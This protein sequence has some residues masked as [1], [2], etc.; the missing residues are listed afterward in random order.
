MNGEV[1]FNLQTFLH[2]MRAEQTA[3]LSALAIEMRGGF[4]KIATTQTAHELEDQI[5]FSDLSNRM[6]PLESTQ[7]SLRWA[8][9]SMIGGLIVFLF[10][11]AHNWWK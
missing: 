1:S 3:A 11:A 2:D 5:K 7:R 6:L 8:I 10:D 9:R 4:E